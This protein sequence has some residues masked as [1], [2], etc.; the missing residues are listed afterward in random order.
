MKLAILTAAVFT[1]SVLFADDITTLSGVKYQ[2]ARVTRIEP[3]A[4]SV[5]HRFG[6]ARIPFSDLPEDI[7]RKYGYNPQQAAAAVK[8]GEA[9]RPFIGMTEAEARARYG[10]PVKQ[11]AQPPADKVLIFEKDG[12]Y[13]ITFFLHGR[14]GNVTYTRKDK[15]PFLREEAEVLLQNNSQAGRWIYRS[16][17]PE[18]QNW[19][20]ADGSMLAINHSNYSGLV[21]ATREYLNAMKRVSADSLKGF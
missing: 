17:V 5:T 15:R 1:A 21:I 19:E 6:V 16:D 2:S 9:A 12:I 7:R 8:Q 14:V 20:A 4:V 3:D 11:G 13:L 18:N 10:E